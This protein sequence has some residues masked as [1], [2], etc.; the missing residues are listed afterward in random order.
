MNLG[1]KLFEFS[2][3]KFLIRQIIFDSPV[4]ILIFT[5]YFGQKNF[6]F[7]NICHFFS[8]SILKLRKIKLKD[9]FISDPSIQKLSVR[10]TTQN[11]VIKQIILILNKELRKNFLKLRVLC[12]LK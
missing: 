1:I 8:L 4:P 5:I 6:S 11:N 12:I 9:A 3:A 2:L 10:R 7:F